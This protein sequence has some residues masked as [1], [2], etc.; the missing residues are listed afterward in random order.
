[1]SNLSSARSLLFAPGNEEHKLATTFLR[2]GAVD[3]SLS[4]QTINQ[5]PRHDSRGRNRDR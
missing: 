3:L 5:T 4:E 2:P 1:M